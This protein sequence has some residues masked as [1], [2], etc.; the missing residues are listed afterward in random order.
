MGVLKGS[1]TVRRYVVRG[2][3]PTERSRLMKGI[4]A[5][6]LLPIDP[7]GDVERS[8]GWA[9]S[10]DP[11]ITDLSSDQVFVGGNLVLAVRVDTL[12]PPAA[13]V[14]RLAN[15]KL[16]A[17]GRPAGKREK[18]EAKDLAR[19][20]L[21]KRAIPSMKAFDLVWALDAG[22]VYF[23]NCGKGPNE[24]LVDLFGKSFDC[25]LVAAGPGLL[26]AQDKGGRGLANLEPTSE[27]FLGFPGLPGRPPDGDDDAEVADA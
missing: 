10:E 14:K 13:A 26:A 21:R 22:T 19:R 24:L 11:E 23:F 2:K 12:K 4:R 16:R 5:H 20:E 27:L 1:V 9:S 3:P 25:E 18:Q 6:A 17:L 7:A 8:H 15:E